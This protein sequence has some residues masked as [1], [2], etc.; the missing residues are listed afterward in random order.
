MPRAK[1]D[2][3]CEFVN[4]FLELDRGHG[5]SY[6]TLKGFAKR[7]GP[8]KE[9]ILAAVARGDVRTARLRNGVK[10]FCIEDVHALKTPETADAQAQ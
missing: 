10:I 3:R 8:D 1:H 5:E 6:A 9:T 4:E 7:R 2:Y